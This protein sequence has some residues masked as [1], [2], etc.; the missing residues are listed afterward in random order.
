MTPLHLATLLTAPFAAAPPSP[1]IAAAH[2][3]ALDLDDLADL[4]DELSFGVAAAEVL[5]TEPSS[6]IDADSRRA[7]DRIVQF[8]IQLSDELAKLGLPRPDE[9]VT[10]TWL[11]AA[12]HRL[13]H[14]HPLAQ[15]DP[16]GSGRMLAIGS[17]HAIE[18]AHL[19]R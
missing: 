14:T 7:A 17:R 8:A 19:R 6:S 4:I 5:L 11:G 18:L 15:I 12:L 1:I 3:A 13:A 10:L 16:A 2:D 9:A